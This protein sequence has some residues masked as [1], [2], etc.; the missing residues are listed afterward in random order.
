MS[1]GELQGSN[2]MVT[3]IK[4]ELCTAAAPAPVLCSRSL[5]GSSK[6]PTSVWAKIEALGV[7]L[8]CSWAA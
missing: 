2:K 3:A 4:F 1:G 5:A 7:I 6:Y 8:Q